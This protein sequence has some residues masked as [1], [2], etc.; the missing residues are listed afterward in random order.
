[1]R[2]NM[3]FDIELQRPC[4]NILICYGIMKGN[5]TVVLIKAGLNGS[6]RGYQ[7]KY[8]HIAM[9]IYR[10]FGYT[11]VCSSNP[12]CSSCHVNPIETDMSVI[13]EIFGKI[14]DN[15]YYMG[16]SNGA[17][18][19]GYWGYKYPQIKRMLLIN[20]P[21]VWN[22]PITK[23]ALKK[24]NGEKIV[25]VFGELDPFCRYADLIQFVQKENIF[26]YKLSNVDHEFTGQL[27]TFIQLPEIYLC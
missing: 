20:P 15:I 14:P 22:W 21:I 16:F 25:Y 23:N 11:V 6:E 26:L 13:W 1:M 8:L 17:L 7:D 12:S 5:D 24:F 4:A 27:E 10:R 3:E 19:G 18:I 2:Y 9:N